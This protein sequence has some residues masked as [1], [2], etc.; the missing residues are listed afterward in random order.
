MSGAA[1]GMLWAGGLGSVVFVLRWAAYDSAPGP[2]LALGLLSAGLI[3]AGLTSGRRALRATLQTRGFRY[4]FGALALTLLALSIAAGVNAFVARYDTRWDVTEGKRYTLSDETILAMHAKLG[5][6]WAEIAKM[7]PGRTDNAIK[8]HWNS[9]LRRELRKLNRQKSAII[10][11]L[12]QGVD[13]AIIGEITKGR[14]R[15]QMRKARPKRR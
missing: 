3:V 1:R 4:S 10:P 5:T 13:A 6:R 8:N 2:W 9:A 14:G 15:V 11:A 12:A 7:L